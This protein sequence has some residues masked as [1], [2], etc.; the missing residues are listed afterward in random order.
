MALYNDIIPKGTVII[1]DGSTRGGIAL[2]VAANDQVLQAD[3]S[4]GS[5]VSWTA[6]PRSTTSR[7]TGT[8]NTGVT[9]VEYGDGYNHVTVLTVSQTN[10]LTLADDGSIC[11]G[12]LLYTL[13]AGACIVHAAYMS[14]SVTAGSAQL[15]ADTPDVG[16]GTVIGT[17]GV[18]VL[19]G[20]GTFENILF[21]LAAADANGTA[22]VKTAMTTDALG[23]L[24]IDT[25]NAHTI[26]FNAAA[27]WSDDTTP[28][29]TA[30]IAGTVVLKWPF[31]A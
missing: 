20:T 25:A 2:T 19:G 15:Q 5:G 11:D 13:P 21:G 23:G 10:S 29:L 27:V 6:N 31:M 24:A 12:Y 9:A 22:T 1:G 18:S 26:H 14:M 3:S 17:G 16:L 4:A 28:D 7:N 30:D 8:V